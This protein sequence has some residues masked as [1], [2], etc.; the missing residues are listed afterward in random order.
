MSIAHSTAVGVPAVVL[1]ETGVPSPIIEATTPTPSDHVDPHANLLERTRQS[2]AHLPAH[3]RSQHV[4][5]KSKRESRQ[6]LFPVN[7]FETPRRPNSAGF[8]DDREEKRDTT[9]KQSL[10]EQDAE[11]ASVFKSRPKIAVSPVLSP[12]RDLELDG[13]GMFEQ[14]E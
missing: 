12:C 11:Y 9:P 1:E 4:R 3:S 10:F 6:S 8:T 13:E 7:Q 2:M 5:R 14:L